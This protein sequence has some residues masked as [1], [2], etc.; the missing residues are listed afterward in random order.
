MIFFTTR[1]LTLCLGP[2]GTIL[3]VSHLDLYRGTVNFLTPFST[4]LE[5][6]ISTEYLEK[7]QQGKWILRSVVY[8]I[9]CRSYSHH[10]VYGGWL[11]EREGH[12][13][14][15]VHVSTLYS[16]AASSPGSSA[17]ASTRNNEGTSGVRT[18]VKMSWKLTT[19]G[20]VDLDR[21]HWEFTN[22]GQD[23]HLIAS[24]PILMF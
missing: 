19:G 20:K 21:D 12:N 17:C 8:D 9:F 22:K 6:W 1:G 5:K 14:R 23:K 18:Y 11:G 24:H 15:A 13:E 3:P 10:L 7:R 2:A 16:Y 4:G